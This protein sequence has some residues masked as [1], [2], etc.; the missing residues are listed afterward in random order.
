ME[1]KYEDIGDL[2]QCDCCDQPQMDLK[3]LGQ[4]SVKI[5]EVVREELSRC[6]KEVEKKT[7]RSIFQFPGPLIDEKG[8]KNFLE[9]PEIAL[10]D[11]ERKIQLVNDELNRR[12]LKNE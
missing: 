7:N 9:M 5:L 1:I 8:T 4:Y 10:K 6:K 2:P 12:I 11:V 3:N